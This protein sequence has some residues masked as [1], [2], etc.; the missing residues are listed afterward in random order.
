MNN[1]LGGE[2]SFFDITKNPD[3]SKFLNECDYIHEPSENEIQKIKENFIPMAICIGSI[4][5]NIIAIDANNYEAKVRDDIPFTNIGI[6]KTVNFLLEKKK[7]SELSTKRFLDPFEVA[8]MQSEH[9]SYIFTFPSSNILYKDEKSVR[10]G[11][12][13]KLNEMFNEFISIKKDSTSSL[14]DTYFWLLDTRFKGKEIE[15]SRC[16]NEKCKKE[17][18][19]LF[20]IKEKQLCPY[21]RQPIYPTDVLRLWEDITEDA[22][23]NITSLTRFTNVIKHIL[24]A[25][26]IR[27][28][29]E[30]NPNN[31]L[32][33]LSNTTFVINGPLAVFG[34]PAWVHNSLMKIIYDLNLELEQKGFKKIKIIGIIENSLLTSY[35][36]FINKHIDKNTLCCVS[37]EFREKYITYSE[38]DPSKTFGLETYYG[39]DFIYKN[40]KGR[41]K[42]FNI[43]YNFENKNNIENFK[44]KKADISEYKNINDYLSF[45]NE[46]DNDMFNN[47]VLPSVICKKYSVINLQPGAK[48]IDL[49]VKNNIN[50]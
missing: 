30:K 16:P 24:L 36:E 29:K 23:S 32:S 15:L 1:N 6:V 5:D 31:Y 18:I 7:I 17:K 37:D 33:I 10:S 13:L 43:P 34:N 26:Y 47:S 40:N 50:N 14:M 25:H 2:S 21:C 28:I 3:I 27:I 8:K 11:F 4:S 9:Q 45:L 19:R 12:R 20:P 38:K 44:I 49:F 41:I 48:I 46:F 42:V 39:Q 22:P 35:A